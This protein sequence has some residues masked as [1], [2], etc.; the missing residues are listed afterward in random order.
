[1]GPRS[2]III[3][4]YAPRELALLG[5]NMKLQ[6][7]TVFVLRPGGQPTHIAI[8]IIQHMKNKTK[9]KVM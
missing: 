4:H 1:M 2:F 3:P 5:M 6:A 7:H 9:G 8:R